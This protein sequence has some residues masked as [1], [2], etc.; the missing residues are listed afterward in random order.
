MNVQGHRFSG[1]MLDEPNPRIE[2]EVCGCVVT[3]EANKGWTVMEMG[4]AICTETLKALARAAVA[5]LKALPPEKL[6]AV[7]EA[8]AAMGEVG[9]P[10]PKEPVGGERGP[11]PVEEDP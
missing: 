10:E 8:L 2:C 7:A 9:Q 6:K 4:P 1:R 5:E 3:G 11:V